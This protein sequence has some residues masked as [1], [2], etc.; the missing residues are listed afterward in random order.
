MHENEVK[1][2]PDPLHDAHREQ[3][4]SNKG[5][6]YSGDHPPEV[7]V[8]RLDTLPAIRNEMGKL[9]RAARRVAGPT[10]SPSEATKLGWLLNALATSVTNSE[11]AARIE[12]L[13]GKER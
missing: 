4:K 2:V 13:E 11:L 3:P 7:R 9:Y 5:A 6:G 1:P 8:G 10:P 12:A